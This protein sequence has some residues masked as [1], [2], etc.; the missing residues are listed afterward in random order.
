MWWKLVKSKIIKQEKTI[1]IKI[2]FAKMVTCCYIYIVLWYSKLQYYFYLSFNDL[3]NK[4]ES[5]PSIISHK[6]INLHMAKNIWPVDMI[7]HRIEIEV[8]M[9]KIIRAYYFFLHYLISS[10]DAAMLWNICILKHLW[11][12]AKN[13]TYLYDYNEYKKLKPSVKE[14]VNESQINDSQYIDIHF[15]HFCD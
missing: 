6:R 1:R 8:N 10:V 15:L 13:K 7:N 9:W 12:I 5:W 14:R 11:R 2:V 3:N 4:S